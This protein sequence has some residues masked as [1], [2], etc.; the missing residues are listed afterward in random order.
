[1]SQFI[2]LKR[3]RDRLR[4]SEHTGLLLTAAAI[5]LLAGLGNVAYRQLLELAHWLLFEQWGR[6][7]GVRPYLPAALLLPLLPL[8]G[9][10]CSFPG[11]M[12]PR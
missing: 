5:G 3:L 2:S 10:L 6:V 1:V 12:G 8:S 9:A 4:L 7:L 11:P